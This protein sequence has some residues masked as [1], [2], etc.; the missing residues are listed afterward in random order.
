VIIDNSERTINE[1]QSPLQFLSEGG[2]YWPQW[3]RYLAIDGKK[4]FHLGNICGTCQF[5]FE[6]MDGANQ[7]INPQEVAAALNS[8]ISSLAPELLYS[9]EKIMPK[10]AYLV[11]LS[12]VKPKIVIP[13]DENDYFTHEQIELWGTDSFW[14]LPHF[15][16][17]EY[18]RLT[19]QLLPE[20]RSLFEFVVPIFP[21]GWLD[22]ER[23][24]E[25]EALFR[26]EKKPT[27]I[28]LSVLDIKGPADWE[29]EKAIVEHACLAH[30]L[31]DGHHK[32]YAAARTG[33]A[34]TMISF[35]AVEQSIASKEDIEELLKQMK[36][37]PL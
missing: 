31:V 19:T 22:T 3:D 1:S 18:Y 24:T 9:L 14:G 28:T 11:L 10:G 12:E 25:Y 15:P 37:S 2:G 35:L 5:F 17:T 8:G 33:R 27:A 32:S 34:M 6:R 29:G 26:Q 23:V 21:H 30:Y 7:S 20:Q 16:K 13:G 36:H 4:A